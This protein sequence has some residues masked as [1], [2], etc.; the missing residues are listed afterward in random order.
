MAKVRR[1]HDRAAAFP[2]ERP[3]AR[4]RITDIPKRRAAPGEASTWR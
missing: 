4:F 3:A 2:G 1:L